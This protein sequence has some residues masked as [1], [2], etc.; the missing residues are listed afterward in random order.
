MP[1]CCALD[2]SVARASGDRLL[3]G[4]I[5]SE[6]AQAFLGV[7]QGFAAETVDL[8]QFLLAEFQLIE[9][10][11]LG[12]KELLEI[13]GFGRKSLADAKKRLRQFGYDL[14]EQEPVT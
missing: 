5:V 10:L 4:E 14:P 2:R 3:F 7:C 8:Q 13:D 12:E 1:A 9:K 11:K 6:L